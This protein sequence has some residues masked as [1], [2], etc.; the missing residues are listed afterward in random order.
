MMMGYG[1]EWGYG[2]SDW[3]SR[4]PS[5]PS[6]P[7]PDLQCFTSLVADPLDS[8]R[9]CLTGTRGC[10]AIVDLIDP[11]GADDVRVKQYTLAMQ[12]GGLR[13]GSSGLR[14]GGGN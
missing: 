3:H 2:R 11:I 14:G 6:L 7:R 9:L 10:L 13:R 4:L 8:R 12:Q 5:T 1:V